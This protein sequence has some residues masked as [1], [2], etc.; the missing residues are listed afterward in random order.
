M[1]SPAFGLFLIP[2][3]DAPG[4][5]VERA[6]RAEA[7][8][9]DLIAVQDHPYQRRH[10]DALALLTFIAAKTS[11]IGL[12]TDVANL[13]LRPP[14]VLAETAA[15]IDV[16]SGGRFELGL[17]AGGFTDAIAS[18]G[19]PRRSGKESVDA[20]EEAIAV[21]RLVWSGESPASYAGEHYRVHG[22][23][24]G[25]QPA[26]PIGIWL[27]AYGPRMMRVT[28]RLAD[29]WLPSVPRMP[30]DRLPARRQAI[31]EA[32][33][34]A[35]RDPSEIRRVANVNGTITTGERGGFLQGPAD[36]WVDDLRR[37]RSEHG[38]D[39][40]VFWGDGDPD[41]QLRRFA[42]DVVPRV[43]AEV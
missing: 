15:S 10:L 20:L 38:F 25:P 19:G 41:V 18:M 37:L 34:R 9:L 4:L 31:D 32:A 13:P 8:G 16:L 5:T 14:A 2:D 40:F 42:E 36:Q 3:A 29:G 23:K 17:G 24:P 22:L 35:G 26:H 11:R 43:R 21:I 12:V 1:I 30:L 33:R 39:G 7:L 28:G 27:G 6:E